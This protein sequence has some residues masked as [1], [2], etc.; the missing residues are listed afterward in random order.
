MSLGGNVFYPM[1]PRWCLSCFPAVWLSHGFLVLSPVGHKEHRCLSGSGEV[2]NFC[3][4]GFMPAPFPIIYLE[5]ILHL[6]PTCLQIAS[7]WWHQVDG[8][9]GW[10]FSAIVSVYFWLIISAPSWEDPFPPC[11]LSPLF[12]Y[13]LLAISHSFCW[14][15]QCFS[16]GGGRMRKEVAAIQKLTGVPI[17]LESYCPI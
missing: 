8:V 5:S 10:A 11:F 1:P 13:S 15:F 6:S 7:L 17:V 16:G 4:H 3:I 2:Y 9:D 12:F 14:L